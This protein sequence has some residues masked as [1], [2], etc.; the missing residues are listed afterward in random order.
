MNEKAEFVRSIYRDIDTREVGRLTAHL[1][2]DCR[3]SFANHGTMIGRDS[4][5]KFMIPFMSSLDG[6]VHEVDEVWDVDNE[7]MFRAKV[8]Y[9][10]K[11]GVVKSYPAAVFWKMRGEKVEDFSVYVD[12]SDLFN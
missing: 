10:R 8:S 4:L 3:F 11:D 5:E 12:S 6:M 7:I 9:T 2:D 1:T